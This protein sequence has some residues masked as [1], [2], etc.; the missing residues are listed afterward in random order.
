MYDLRGGNFFD[1]SIGKLSSMYMQLYVSTYL[2]CTRIY[3]SRSD[4]F[5]R[6]V[7]RRNPCVSMWSFRACTCVF[8]QFTFDW[9]SADFKKRTVGLWLS[10]EY[11]HE[12]WNMA[13]RIDELAELF[14]RVRFPSTTT[15]IPRSLKEYAKFKGNEFRTLLL[16]AHVIFK[17]ALRKRFYNPLLQLVVIMHIA[18]SRQ[19]DQQDIDLITRLSRTF[20]VNFVELY[21]A[22]HCVPVIHSISH[23]AG[24][25]HEFG[26]LPNFTTFQFE[27]NL[28][29]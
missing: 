29:K 26:P 11:R 15:R 17:Q 18:E 1:P 25:L 27:N 7:Y 28:G 14:R 10:V 6:R 4:A 3:C 9:V 20:V 2:A 23:I 22:R 5:T 24:T 19:I 13:E 16:F 12:A 8:K 21:G